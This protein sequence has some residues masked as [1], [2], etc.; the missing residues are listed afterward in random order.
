[1]GKGNVKMPFWL[2]ILGLCGLGILLIAGGIVF[3]LFMN[4]VLIHG[5]RRE[6]KRREK[7]VIYFRAE[8]WLP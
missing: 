7:E 2:V 6:Q 5:P 3:A 4:E 1:M 8:L